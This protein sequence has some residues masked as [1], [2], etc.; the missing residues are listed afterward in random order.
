LQ[1]LNFEVVP[2]LLNLSPHPPKEK[3]IENHQ[4]GSNQPKQSVENHHNPLNSQT[5]WLVFYLRRI[6][7][8][9]RN[10]RTWTNLMNHPFM[11]SLRSATYF[12]KHEEAVFVL[13]EPLKI[14]HSCFDMFSMNR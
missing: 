9:A 13:W 6:H 3:N 7:H 8:E 14:I 12:D 11:F 1:S 10:P 5:D 4:D 2:K